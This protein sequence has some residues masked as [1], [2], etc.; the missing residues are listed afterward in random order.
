MHL[1]AH[2]EAEVAAWVLSVVETKVLRS[3]R[4]VAKMWVGTKALVATVAC[5]LD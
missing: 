5:S 4:T 1:D 3:I 2:W